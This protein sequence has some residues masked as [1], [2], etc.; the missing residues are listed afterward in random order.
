[1][2]PTQTTGSTSPTEGKNQKQDKRQPYSLGKGD[3]K[4][5]K[6]DTMRRQMIMQE[7]KEQDKN[8][9]DHIN[10]E[11]IGKLPERE[12]RV[13]T[14]KIIQHLENIMEKNA[15]ITEHT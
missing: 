6:L 3:F 2:K 5:S 7:M 12:F 10:K 4:H 14:V 15:R 11:G 8:P 1:M 13:M 9:H